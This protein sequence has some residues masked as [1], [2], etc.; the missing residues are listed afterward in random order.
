MRCENAFTTTDGLC[1][2]RES[3][4]FTMTPLSK[5]LLLLVSLAT[6]TVFAQ[7]SSPPRATS[8]P[9]ATAQALASIVPSSATYGYFGCYNETTLNSDVGNVRALAG[10][11]MVRCLQHCLHYVLDLAIPIPP[12]STPLSLQRMMWLTLSPHRPHQKL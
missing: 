7:T 6:S 12:T 4:L 2:L 5:S 10:G 1:Q 3:P 8:P 9:S 11:N